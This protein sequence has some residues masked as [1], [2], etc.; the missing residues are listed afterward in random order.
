[1]TTAQD[2]HGQGPAAPC[3]ASDPKDLKTVT[4]PVCQNGGSGH[5]QG[6]DTE[7]PETRLGPSSKLVRLFSVNRKRMN[8]YPERPRSVVMMGNSSTWNALASFRKM[9]SFKKLRASVLQGI[10]NR[11][12]ADSSK[13]EV[14]E[15]EV[16]S[17]I[18]NGAIVGSHGNRGPTGGQMSDP[19]SVGEEAVSDCSDPEDEDA[20]QRSTHRSRSIRRA[21]G[22]G[23]ISLLDS[24][25]PL[26]P[27]GSAKPLSLPSQEPT[28][29][30]ILVRDPD[31][32]SSLYRRSKSTDSLNFL[33]KSSFK[34]KSTS[35]LADLRVTGDS[36]LAPQRTLSSSS[37]DSEKAGGAERRTKRWKSPIRA[38]D[39]DRV[40]KL[41]SN[42][43]DSSWKR[44]VPKTG[45]LAPGEA[46][47][48]LQTQ[49]R[50]H[51]DYSRRVSS[52]SEQDRRP[53]APSRSPA[54]TQGPAIDVDTAVVPL[55]LELSHQSGSTRPHS[56]NVPSSP[57]DQQGWTK[58]SS[59]DAS[60]PRH[61]LTP[62]LPITPKP[63]SPQS[64]W[65]GSPKCPTSLT[66]LSLSSE[67]GEDRIRDPEQMESAP[68][69]SQDWAPT[70]NTDE[71]RGEGGGSPPQ[72]DSEEQKE[73]VTKDT[74][75]P[76]S[77]QNEEPTEAPRISKRR[78]GSGRRTRPRPLSDYGQLATRSLSIPEDTVAVDP[79]GEDHVDGAPGLSK[80]STS[81]DSSG[82]TG[83]TRGGRRR[84]PMSV[85]G[86]VSLYG[87]S[88]V[89]DIENLLTQPAARPPVPAHQVPPYKAVSARLRPF[90]FSQST[91]IG[92]D[93]VGRRR[94]MRT[95][96]VSSDGGTESSALVDDNGSEEDFSYEELCQAN[97]RYLQPGGEQLAINELICDGSMVCAE[98][99][100]DH[101][102]MDDQELGFKAGD[103]IQVLEASNKD[104]WW[105]RNED[106]EAWFPASFVRL[107][108]NQEELP[109][110][111]SS[112]HGEQQEKEASQVRHKL[113]ESKQ[114][115]RTNVIQEIMNTERVYIKHLKDICE[116]YIRQ[117]RKHTGMFTVAQLATIFGNIEDIYKFQRKFLKD[118][119]RQYNKEEPHL[120]EIGSCFLQHQEGFAI[121]SE[122][123]NNHPGACVE[124]SNLM[125]QG[126]YRHFF[127]ACRLLQQMIDI[128]LDGFLL[129]PVQKICKY[130]LQLAELLKYT[131]Q[132]H[133][134]YNNI[135][136]A[137]EAMKHVA[138]LINE[139]KR[140][141]E[142]I[143]K[144]ARWQLSIVGWEGLDILDRSSEL[145]HSGELTRITKQG[146]SQQRTFF[147]FDHQLVV[148]KKDLLRR[149]MLYY[150]GRMDMDE[151]E[152]IDVEDG[153]DKDCNLSVRN[154]FKLISKTADEVHLFCAKKQEDKARWLQACADE[155]QR[156]QEDQEM[157][158]EI[159]ESQRKLAMLNAQ[160]TGQSKSKGYN[161][162][163][164]APPHQ[165]LPPLHQRH[166]TVPTSVPQQQVFALAEPKRKPSLFWHTFHKLTPFR[167]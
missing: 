117:C 115:M 55:K 152:L 1:M 127:E 121:Y 165:S 6:S 141:L 39:F 42:V 25:K 150:K 86:G 22:L 60:D 129:T 134:D 71:G 131:T 155:R 132:E 5:S 114:Q 58:V 107:R 97:P 11:E 110:N 26:L 158:M 125:K 145:I 76:S 78:W 28:L 40:L 63:Q 75:R 153:R 105:G 122:Y 112:P 54:A 62:L 4:S 108:V 118:L 64:P 65:V 159:P 61:V 102:T 44:E 139:R 100:W 101:V 3:S 12:G 148:C 9:G 85:I 103:V 133:S 53:S 17:A 142:S 130:P 48:R 43:K 109:E 151:M 166:I 2:G 113:T 104:W 70:Q 92:L 116:G 106:K 120:S 90:T 77:A 69:S 66:M 88:Q 154:A 20:F 111:S 38:K 144:N 56:C 37:A 93:R 19:P 72:P 91:P 84:R 45:P 67:D 10:Q 89:E 147:L 79:P 74:W 33:K 23:R 29:C 156:V 146:K 68:G 136:A 8:A 82:S 163:P 138:C 119:E 15:Q 7:G 31:S 124:L 34:R 73:E 149:D 59:D 83:C 14:W 47:L 51:D 164:A 167:K 21:Y 135:K 30:E 137:Y 35:N 49:S 162:C 98:A 143:D 128:A 87:T 140:K 27:Q 52:S 57:D 80:I 96:N 13:E 94:Q 157:G 160:K 95:S 123:C 99:L 46:G 81:L 32:Q 41:V 161:G 24:D 16:S 18:P 50:L 36:K 126:K